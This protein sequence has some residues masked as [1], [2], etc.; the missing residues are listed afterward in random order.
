MKASNVKKVFNWLKKYE[1][2]NGTKVVAIRIGCQ[3]VGLVDSTGRV[4][5][6]DGIQ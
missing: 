1:K 6:V 3:S 4:E 5:I 2:E